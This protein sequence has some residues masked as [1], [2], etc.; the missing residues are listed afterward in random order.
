MFKHFPHFPHYF[1]KRVPLQV[2]ELFASSAIMDFAGSAIALFEPIYLWT[3]G[4]RVREI[5]LFYLMVY[6]VYFFLLPL[7]GKFVARYGHERSILISTIWLVLYFLALVGIRQNAQLFLVAPLFFALQKT[8]YWPAYHFDL[9][10]FAVK[11][12]RASE[13]SALWSLTTLMYVIGPIAGGVIVK[14]FGFPQLFLGAAFLILLSSAPHF[15][16][17]S[18]PKHEE[19]SY[20]QSFILPFRRRYWRN[21]IGYLGLGEELIQLT[22]WPI[23]I[24]IILADLFNVGLIVGAGAFVTAMVTLMIG[25]WTDRTAKHNVLASGGVVTSG[26]WLLRAVFRSVPIVF[27]LDTFGRLSHNT[28]FVSMTTMT[29]DRAHAD[30]YSWHGVYYEQGFAIAKTFMALLVIAFASIADPFQGAF[31][32]ASIVSLFY[33]VF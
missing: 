12:E 32:A 27:L 22:L 19:Y 29:Y 2:E 16:S 3:L 24:S 10:R 26:V 15:L 20:R 31:V 33:L 23:L 14:F 4:Y 18:I 21:T 25:K 6:V 28:T 17:P 13:F 9:L 1:R 7:G 8:F 11:E 30:D 5:M